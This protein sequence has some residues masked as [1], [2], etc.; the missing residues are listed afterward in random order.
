MEFIDQLI[1]GIAPDYAVRRLKARAAVKAHYEASRPTRT[2]KNQ[3]DNNS[4]NNLVGASAEILR[5]QGRHLEQNH[6][7]AKGALRELTNKTVGAK[8]IQ[9]ES[10]ART[11]DGKIAA[12]FTARINDLWKEWCLVC[13]VSGELSFSQVQRLLVNSKY[14]DGEAFNRLIQGNAP[15]LRH[16]TAVNLSLNPF[17]SDFVPFVSDTSN[18]LIQGIKR[19]AWGRATAYLVLKGHPSESFS[20]DYREIFANVMCHSRTIERLGQ[21]RG[22]SVFASVV[23]RLN[24][25]KDYEDSERVAARISAAMAAYV[26]KGT[27]D[28]YDEDAADEDRAIGIESG[29]VFDGLLPGEDVGT[30]ESNRPSQLLQPFRDS[31]LKAVAVGTGAGY[32]PIS[33][34]YNGTYSAQRQ[35]LVD[36]WINYEVLQ[37]EFIVEVIRPTFRRFVQMCVSSGLVSTRALNPDTI[38]DADYRGPVMPWIDPLKEA[39]AHKVRLAAGLISPQK[40]MRQAGENPQEV[41]DQMKAYIDMLEKADLARPEYLQANETQQAGE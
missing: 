8:G 31:M 17:E 26:K 20:T 22:V 36:N 24:D 28:M 12:D 32:S 21:S 6:D 16:N 38:Y 7:L 29:M 9:V 13:D 2:R 14:R 19:N 15:G 23:N 18:N 34:D 3:S 30:I 40:V 33:N 37:D 10:L 5:G 41:I 4:A 35:Q 27:P 39:N 25:L 1:A 11:P